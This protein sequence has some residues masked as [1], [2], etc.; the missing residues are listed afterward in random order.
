MDGMTASVATI[1]AVDEPE[2]TIYIL[3]RPGHEPVMAHWPQPLLEIAPDAIRIQSYS[4]PDIRHGIVVSVGS[5]SAFSPYAAER[6][7]RRAIAAAKREAREERKAL[8]EREARLK[9]WRRA[10]PRRFLRTGRKHNKNAK[11]SEDDIRA[12]QRRHYTGFESLRSISRELWQEKGF[13]SPQSM[14]NTL[15]GTLDAYGLR[16]RSREEMVAHTNRLR[17]MR[18][19]GETESEFKKRRRR[20]RGVVHGRVCIAV[21]TRSGRG[22]GERCKKPALNDS[23]YC[24]SHDHRRMVWI[25]EHLKQARAKRDVERKAV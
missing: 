4:E 25:S 2:S 12:I 9:A 8:R 10:R 7:E 17:S 19:P 16:R 24:V 23:E 5:S 6:E 13:S 18:L 1:Q 11:L 20:E 22:R 3:R 14:L 15:C 21:K